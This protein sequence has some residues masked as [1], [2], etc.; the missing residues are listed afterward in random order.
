MLLAEYEDYTSLL[1]FMLANAA[2]AG[3]GYLV[4][5]A[6]DTALAGA[7]IAVGSAGVAF[8][9]GFV[10]AAAFTWD[11]V[12]TQNAMIVLGEFRDGLEKA[13]SYYQEGDE[14]LIH[15][16][17]KFMQGDEIVIQVARY[18]DDGYRLGTV[19]RWKVKTSMIDKSGGFLIDAFVRYATSEREKENPL[20]YIDWWSNEFEVSRDGWYDV[21]WWGVEEYGSRR[22]NPCNV[23]RD[24]CRSNRVVP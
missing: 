24:L 2:G 23:Y 21:G 3:A 4:G 9:G 18:T 17:E 10:A 15:V 11:G 14:F 1:D 12:A 6:I 22:V 20:R 5:K 19:Y 16:D 8:L 7:G 13:L